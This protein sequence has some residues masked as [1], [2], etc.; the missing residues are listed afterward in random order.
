M[1]RVRIVVRGRVQGV[2]F[3]AS[4]ARVAHELGLTGSVSNRPD[5]AVEVVVAGEPEAVERMI[6]WCHR[7]PELA[8][9]DSLEVSEE[10]SDVAETEFRIS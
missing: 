6:A 1:R 10:P 3:R 5:G 8:E 9:V 4:A 2:F 7:G